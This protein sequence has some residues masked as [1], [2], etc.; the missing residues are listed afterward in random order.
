VEWIK[1]EILF[2]DRFD[3]LLETEFFEHKVSLFLQ[4]CLYETLKAYDKKGTLAV[5]L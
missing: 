3:R 1:S 2:D 4:E 5:N